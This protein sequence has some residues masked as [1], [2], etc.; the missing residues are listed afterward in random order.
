VAADPT[1]VT[2]VLADATKAAPFQYSLLPF[3]KRNSTR[4]VL[5]LSCAVPDN[6]EM[7]GYNNEFCGYWTTTSGELMS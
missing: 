7:L 2:Q 6:T 4:F 1:A 3:F 5:K